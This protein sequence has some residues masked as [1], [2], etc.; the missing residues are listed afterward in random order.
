[1]TTGREWATYRRL[2]AFARPYWFRIVAGGFFGVVFGGS[3]T[4]LLVALKNTLA[5]VFNPD[6]YSL[7]AAFAVAVSLPMIGL[8]RGLGFYASTYL[9]EWVGNR[10]VFDLRAAMF[11]RLQELSIAFYGANR[12]GDLISR[13]TNDT[14]MVERAVSTVL[15]DLARQPFT[16]LGLVG[17][18][19]WLDWK[20][21][22][23]SLALFPICIL[24][25]A[26]FGRRVRRASRE[27]Q[28]R[29]ADLVSILE[30]TIAGARIVKA[31]GMEQR[32]IARFV[33]RSRGVFSRAMRVTRARAAIE[34]IIVLISLVGFGLILLYARWREMRFEEFFTFGAALVAMYEPVK[35]LSRIH[36]NIQQSSAAADRIFELLDQ[37]VL[38]REKPGARPLAEPIERIAFE[39]VSFAYGDKLVLQDIEFEA[40]RGACIALVGASGSGKTTLVSLLPRFYDVTGGRITINGTDIREFTLES[41]RRHI[42]LVTQE[43]VLFNDSVANNIAY[44]SPSASRAQI[45]DAARRAH[46]HE[47]ILE[48]PEG[49]DT[50]IGDRGSRL[51][52]GQRQRLAIARAL[53]R[54]APVLILDEATSALDTESE[55]LVQAALDRLMSGRTVFAIAHRLSTIQHADLILVLEQ[56]RIAERGTHAEL[57]AAGGLYRRLY[58]MQF[59]M[60]AARDS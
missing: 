21:A 38:V 46:A 3:T 44:G 4:A 26:L 54:D 36:L 12:A 37:P 15:A 23:I 13:T 56:G 59:N 6:E 27:G 20:L 58:D 52:G 31:F 57:I 29:M 53:L 41:L 45:E 17:F 39:R 40:R 2:L 19:L 33:E 1:M 18:L 34:P 55:R 42:S 11:A 28:E 22:V 32:E 60:A 30:E 51:S 10:V 49:Y 43:T 25:V 50:V 47:F 8:A 9:L 35:K 14:Q 48:L 24:P 16:F 7:A 5:R